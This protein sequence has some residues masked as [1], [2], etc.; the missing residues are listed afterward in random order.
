MQY[1]P[2]IRDGIAG[3]LGGESTA[4]EIVLLSIGERDSQLMRLRES[5][6]GPDIVGAVTCPR[7]SGELELNFA[8]A[9]IA[10]RS[11]ASFDAHMNLSG[12]G[13]HL[14]FRVPNSLD[15]AAIADC[16][17]L[18]T[19]RR[20]LLERCLLSAEHDGKPLGADQLPAE[21][22]AEMSEC[23]ANADP[24]AD[25]Q[26]A[27]SCAECGQAWRQP[28][29]ILAFFWSEIEAWSQ[30]ILNEVHVLASRYGWSEAEILSLS[31]WRRQF[32]LEIARG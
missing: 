22:Q 19:G 16:M 1:A 32:Y 21:I 26:I 30:R 11:D 2:N 3:H 9:S 12:N 24:G 25:I 20:A 17:D 14:R 7:C 27:I 15:L 31:P 4:E 29:D 13:Y 8:L 5:T 10:A 23:V 6:F 28:F 18:A